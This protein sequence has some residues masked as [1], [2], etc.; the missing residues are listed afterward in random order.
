[1]QAVSGVALLAAAMA[2]VA[3]L[4]TSGCCSGG[5]TVNMAAATATV[6]NS[7]DG[8]H[9]AA[10]TTAHSTV[11]RPGSLIRTGSLRRTPGEWTRP[12]ACEGTWRRPQQSKV[13]C[14]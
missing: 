13:E 4:G 1:M 14:S 12:G 2:V 5:S 7:L 11:R 3:A 10:R 8:N 6:T 9:L